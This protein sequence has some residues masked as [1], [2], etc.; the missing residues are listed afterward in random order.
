MCQPFSGN[1]LL[2]PA[3]TMSADPYAEALI[4][5][6]LSGE[7]LN[8]AEAAAVKSFIGKQRAAAK[9]MSPMAKF[10][11]IIYASFIVLVFVLLK[12]ATPV[13]LTLPIVQWL[14]PRY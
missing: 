13:D 1:K 12:Y 5:R 10:D 2:Q 6:S 8:P 9:S 4:K 11:L 3:L 14:K 7:K